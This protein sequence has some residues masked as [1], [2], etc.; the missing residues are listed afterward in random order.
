MTPCIVLT[1]CADQASAE[2]PAGRI[3]EARLGACVQLET[4]TSFYRWEGETVVDPE[5]RVVIKSHR[6]HYEVLEALIVK[7]HTYE[8]PQILMV[9]VETGYD[10]CLD[11]SYVA[12]ISSTFS[13]GRP[14]TALSP[15]ITT[16]RSMRR[17]CSAIAAISAASSSTDL[18]SSSL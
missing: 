7:H 2:T 16:G 4:I 3:L 12:M 13:G 1:T 11:G 18:S 5:V 15:L 8:V 9:D 14:I 6:E 10:P 17:G